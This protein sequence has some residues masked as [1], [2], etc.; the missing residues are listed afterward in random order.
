MK[1]ENGKSKGEKRRKM[2]TIYQ[3]WV[4]ITIILMIDRILCSDSRYS[5]TVGSSLDHEELVLNTLSLLHNLT[6]FLSQTDTDEPSP[7][8][9]SSRL[10]NPLVQASKHAIKRM[11][12]FLTFR[13]LFLSLSLPIFG[14]T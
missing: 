3:M 9:I 6:Y 8:D 10:L 2:S 11:P 4:F 12:S 1:E 7:D 13:S 14:L 5:E